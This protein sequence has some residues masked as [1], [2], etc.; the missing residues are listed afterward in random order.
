MGA[1]SLS[2]AM[3]LNKLFYGLKRDSFNIILRFL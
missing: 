1:S 3:G 2:F